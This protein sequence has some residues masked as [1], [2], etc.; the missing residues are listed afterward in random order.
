MAT[1]TQ[2]TLVSDGRAADEPAP[3]PLTEIAVREDVSR[4]WRLVFCLVL[5]VAYTLLC[6]HYSF[7]HSK[8]MVRPLWDDVAYMTDALGRMEV[9]YRD[10]PLAALNQYFKQPSHAPGSTALGIF[11]YAL[12]GRNDWACYA[13]NGIIVFFLLAFVDAMLVGV[14]FWQRVLVYLFVLSC[15]MSGTAI[16]EFR[17]D[18]AWGIAVAA[19][20]VLTVDRP[21]LGSS[22]RHKINVGLLFGVA[23]A[24]KP[25]ICPLTIALLG[26]SLL[27]AAATDWLTARRTFRLKDVLVAWIIPTAMAMVVAGWYYVVAFAQVRGYI[28]DQMFGKYRNLW[29]LKGTLGFHLRY[30]ITGNGGDFMLGRTLYTVG[31]AAAVGALTVLLFGDRTRK[32][33]LG[34]LAGVMFMAYIVPALNKMKNEF[35]GAGFQAL[36]LLGAV[37]ALALLASRAVRSAR[38]VSWE[39]VAFLVLSIAGI[40]NFQFPRWNGSRNMGGVADHRVSLERVYQVLKDDD[41]DRSGVVFVTAT[42]FGCNAMS[43]Q[44]LSLLDDVPLRFWTASGFDFSEY[45]SGF[46]QSEYVVASEPGNSDTAPFDQT[47][48]NEWQARTL[49][50]IR[51]DRKFEQ[52]A[53]VPT[54]SGKSYF[55]FGRRPP[56]AGWGKAEG[57]MPI[58]GP[59]PQWHMPQVRNGLAP[60]TTL[61]FQSKGGDVDFVMAGMTW[62]EGQEV[63]VALDDQ[64]VGSY[65]FHHSFAFE[66]A[67]FE[68]KTTPGRHRITLHYTKHQENSQFPNAVAFSRLQVLQ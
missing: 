56:F 59:Y 64:P 65:T 54:L 39:L 31:V 61:Q 34:A 27:L 44:Y 5:T 32:F 15:R 12:F 14:R 28:H 66:T 4:P 11:S 52:I 26:L 42:G 13:G 60:E 16:V 58:E 45:A 35:F 8:L 55:I 36:L 21:L 9:F 50:L 25:T 29:R 7:E 48:G 46:K 33:R 67:E 62:F 6:L 30:F 51:S 24:M 22:L 2:D 63:T 19:G 40:L 17:P 53:A 38:R 57:L 47:P 41:K 23:L 20:C 37:M 10:G 49:A 43:L 68:A 18:I 3:A 1:L